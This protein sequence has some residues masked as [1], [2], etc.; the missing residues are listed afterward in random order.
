M[1]NILTRKN[2]HSRETLKKKIPAAR[3]FSA[4]AITFLMVRPLLELF[5]YFFDPSLVDIYS[6]LSSSD[7]LLLIYNVLSIIDLQ[8]VYAAR[9]VTVEHVFC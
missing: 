9:D 7:A 1:H 2:I 4:P 8:Y 3:K 6:R 5:R